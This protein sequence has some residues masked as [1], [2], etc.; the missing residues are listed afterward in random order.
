MFRFI[1][2]SSLALIG[3]LACASFDIPAGSVT[4]GKLH[5]QVSQSNDIYNCSITTSVSS[6]A[7][8]I[9]LKDRAGSD[10]SAASPCKIAFRNATATTGTYSTVSSTAATSVVISSGSKLGCFD[11]AACTLY[12]YAIN[13]G[14]TIELGVISGA[15]LDEGSVQ[16]ST[17]E[18]GAGAAD[19]AVVLYSTTAR[20][21]KAVRLL[22]RVAIT[23]STAGTWASNA[24]EVSNRPF[25]SN[26]LRYDGKAAPM[27]YTATLAAPSGGACTVS[28]ENAEWISGNASSS[29]TGICVVT[30]QTGIFS[31]TP[32]CWCT[33]NTGAG[34]AHY[35]V[36]T[37]T[38]A[39]SVST[40]YIVS[41][42]TSNQIAN[43]YC[44]GTR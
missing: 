33:P 29:G 43:L 4:L 10:P 17:A 25:A 5:A 44:L 1:F 30:I 37:M 39:T 40:T 32:F 6:N 19:S 12:V 16:S 9:A 7:L 18:G 41:T 38:S 15:Q 23:E 31:A 22:G 14:G 27:I 21:S 3:S 8:T 20:A 13:N 28:N 35:C 34:N 11:S 26:S 2:L 24:T 42:S 36:P